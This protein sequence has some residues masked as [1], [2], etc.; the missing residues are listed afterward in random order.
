MIGA[1]ID[2]EGM[3]ADWRSV[4]L[5]LMLGIVTVPTQAALPQ[6]AVGLWRVAPEM[7]MNGQNISKMI[8]ALREPKEVCVA[9][10]GAKMLADP[11]GALALWGKDLADKGCV[12]ERHAVIG[13]KVTFEGVCKG[14]DS[15]FQGN[16]SGELLYHSKHE[17]SAKLLGAGLPALGGWAGALQN[18]A[19]AAGQAIRA[20]LTAQMQWQGEACGNAPALNSKR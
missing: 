17:I 10:Q 16:V 13:N 3:K 7:R 4:L 20:E 11:E 19:K 9:A 15:L 14:K 12:I 18:A 2:G 8:S 1:E 6:P 5:G